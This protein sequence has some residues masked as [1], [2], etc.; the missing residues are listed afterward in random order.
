MASIDRSRPALAVFA[1]ATL[2]GSFQGVAAEGRNA[3]PR[4]P[5][6]D[7]LLRM[8][9]FL[10]SHPD[11]RFRLLGMER[12]QQERYEE[13]LRF[14]RRSGRYADKLSQ[15]VVAEMLWSGRGQEADRAL[16]YA[17]MD[18]AAERGYRLLVMQRERYWSDLDEA[19]RARALEVG[20]EVLAEYG[21]A[22]AQPRIAAIL[23]RARRN[24]T[25][26][27][28]GASAGRNLEVWVPGPRGAAGGD[29]SFG[30]NAFVI[31]GASFYDPQFWDPE[32]YQAWHDKMWEWSESRIG[33]VSVGGLESLEAPKPESPEKEP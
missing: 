21:D 26:S 2:L 5:T 31:S 1:L 28:T 12:L 8:G 25:G 16:A 9:G 13:A 7:R 23:R 29:S 11:L 10:D 32:Q 30:S 15:G 27:R 20:Q 14:F 4:D 33:R 6:G 17:W 18:V 24:V 3:P 22:A 19:E